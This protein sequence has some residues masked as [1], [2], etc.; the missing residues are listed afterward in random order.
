MGEETRRNFMP[1]GSAQALFA[2]QATRAFG[3]AVQTPPDLDQQQTE[4]LDGIIDWMQFRS[5]GDLA[6][7]FTRLLDT[8]LELTIGTIAEDSRTI[9]LDLVMRAQNT[10][11]KDFGTGP[12]PS[13]NLHT[14]LAGTILFQNIVFGVSTDLKSEFVHITSEKIKG[15]TQYY[16]SFYPYCK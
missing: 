12:I 4:A 5:T 11:Q 13:E 6:R 2:L 15:M 8:K 7:V 16:C 9:L 14:V 1:A 10:L 3:Q